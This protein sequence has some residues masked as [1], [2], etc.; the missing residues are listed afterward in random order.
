MGEI[1]LEYKIFVGKPEL[2]RPLKILGC[3]EEENTKIHLT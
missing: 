3:E 2:N 1:R